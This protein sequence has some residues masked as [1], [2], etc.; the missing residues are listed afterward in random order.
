MNSLAPSLLRGIVYASNAFLLWKDL[1][2]RFDKVNRMRIYQ[3]HKEINS[4]SQ[5]PSTLD[6][7]FTRRK[8]LWSEFDVMV[9]SPDCG[10]ARGKEYVE[11]LQQQRL[12]QFVGGLNDSYDQARR[13]ILMKTSEPTL[14]QAYALIIE[15]E[16]Q[17]G[18]SLNIVP[19]S[20]V[21]GNDITTLWSAR[22]QS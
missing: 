21:G 20:I 17:K 22:G 9:P 16:C 18:F 2:E 4:I 12:L 5:G 14:N 6:E 13:Q 19:H 8:E 10:C 3:L 15:D 7:Y 1:K 11:H